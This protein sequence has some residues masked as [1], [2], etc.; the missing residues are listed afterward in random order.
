MV[1]GMVGFTGRL[2]SVGPSQA[3]V[4]IGP[5]WLPV[6]GDGVRGEGAGRGAVLRRR[7]RPAVRR[8]RSR[9][10]L[11]PRPPGRSYHLLYSPASE[12][13]GGEEVGT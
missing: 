2:D 12:G 1:P 13:F 11:L 9:R 6:S 8:L 10:L 3:L 7:R 5:G 4:F